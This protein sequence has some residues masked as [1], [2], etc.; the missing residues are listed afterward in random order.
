MIDT[1]MIEFS[2]YGFGECQF[3]SPGSNLPV[4]RLTQSVNGGCAVYHSSGDDLSIVSEAR[5]QKSLEIATEILDTI[6][7]NGHN[8]NL[9]PN[10]EPQLGK[11][12]L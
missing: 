5:L 10:C 7:G 3:G 12:G 11:R 6:E 2:P 1:D 8:I 9:S 4:G